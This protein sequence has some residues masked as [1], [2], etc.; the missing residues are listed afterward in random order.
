[1]IALI[2]AFMTA[3]LA[4]GLT[5]NI[6][7][8]AMP[9]IVD[10]RLSH[11]V[12][13]AMPKIIEEWLGL[14]LPLAVTGGITTAIFVCGALTQIL[15]GQL[16][17]RFEPTGLFATISIL[18]PVGLVLAALTTGVPMAIGLVL[19][20][21]AIYGQIVINDAMVGRYVPD[22]YRNRFYSWRFFI[23]F[24]AGGLAVPIIGALHAHGGFRSVLL[25]TAGVGAF[26]F[27]S[28]VAAWSLTRGRLQA[29][30]AAGDDR[31]HEP[32]PA[33]AFLEI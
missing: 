14:S 20:T 25:A 6:V 15:A 26:V 32:P 10:E 2:A 3:V 30:P 12:T 22:E 24:T 18:Q 19:V 28:A 29:V 23:G 21:A 1:M 5:F 13:I 9:K 8:I 7:T 31:K 11:I 4:S 27:A 33:E 17:D 16:I